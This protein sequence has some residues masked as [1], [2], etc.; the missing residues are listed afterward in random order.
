GKTEAAGER[1]QATL[2]G[3]REGIFQRLEH[4]AFAVE[5]IHGVLGEVAHL[6]AAA[7]RHRAVVGLGRAGYQLQQRRLAGAIDA[8]HAPPLPA[9]DH[10]IEP[11]IDGAAAITLVDV[12]QADDI[13]ARAR[14]RQ[15]FER[16]RLASLRRLDA[17]DLV[18]LLDPA[19]HL[20]G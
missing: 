5:Q 3:L 8:H 4:R 20:G 11:L 16:H 13:L 15:E 18:E 1:A 7:D 6:D 12:L 10:E 2:A 17:L 19:L 9:A 14:R